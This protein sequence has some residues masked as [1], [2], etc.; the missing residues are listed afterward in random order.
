MS[1]VD[2]WRMLTGA[3]ALATMAVFF[4]YRATP[5]HP[6]RWPVPP[7]CSAALVLAAGA[8]WL[9]ARLLSPMSTLFAVLAWLMLGLTLCPVLAALWR[10]RWPR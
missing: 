7:A 5:R 2:E 4:L 9:T 8:L 1:T 10:Q 6:R 3:I